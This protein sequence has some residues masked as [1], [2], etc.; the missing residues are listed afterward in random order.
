MVLIDLR[1]HGNSAS[2][3]NLKPPHDIFAA[4]KDVAD[5]IEGESWSTPDAMIAHSLGG[6]VVLEFAKKAATG[7]YGALKPPKQVWTT[8]HCQEKGWIWIV[9]KVSIMK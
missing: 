6:K 2:L 4:A 5:L 1:N 7:A 9:P 3:T 8:D